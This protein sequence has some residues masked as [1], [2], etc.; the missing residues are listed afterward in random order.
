MICA[1]IPKRLQASSLETV[2]QKKEFGCSAM[3]C[4]VMTTL[5]AH[6]CFGF[7][8]SSH[9]SVFWHCSDTQGSQIE[10]VPREQLQIQNTVLLSSCFEIFHRGCGHRICDA[11][12]PSALVFS[13]WQHRL[14]LQLQLSPND[15][16]FCSV[17]DAP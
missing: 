1:D 11:C 8:A 15:Q 12:C 7:P 2:Q 4:C 16:G 17:V 10:K 3:Q 14:S 9:I 6:H 13:L 5:D